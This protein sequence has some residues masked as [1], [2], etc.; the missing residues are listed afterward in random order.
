MTD[1]RDKLLADLAEIASRTG[2]KE[3]SFQ[4]VA[5][6]LRASGRYRWVG[7]YAVDHALGVVT[8]IA[9]S[10][11]GAP[12]YRTFPV[13]EGLTGRAVA[14][15]GT[16]NVGDVSA[17]PHYL[18]AFAT[19]RSEIIVPVFDSAKQRVLGTIDV[20]SEAPSTFSND[21]Q[22]LLEACAELV[23]PLWEGSFARSVHPSPPQG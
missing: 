22:T 14:R 16:V 9:F 10:G 3:V 23:R 1:N 4:R 7:L 8:N 15:R 11:P 13:T 18:T 12:Q 5:D 17:D 20:E 6:R 2:D 21:V 19:T